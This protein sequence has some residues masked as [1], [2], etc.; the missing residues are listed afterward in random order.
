MLRNRGLGYWQLLMDVAK[1]TGVTLGEKLQ[2]GNARGMAHGF[3]KTG[4]GLLV[5]T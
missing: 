1:I 5:I 3:G 4:N 2:Y